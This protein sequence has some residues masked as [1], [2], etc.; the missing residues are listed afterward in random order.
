MPAPV[1]RNSAQPSAESREQFLQVDRC[2]DCVVRAHRQRLERSLRVD[3]GEG[4]HQGNRSPD[5]AGEGRER[6]L[7][8][9]IGQAGG[10]QNEIGRRSGWVFGVGPFRLQQLIAAARQGP[11]EPV[12]AR[13]GIA[14]KQYAARRRRIGQDDRN[15]NGGRERIRRLCPVKETK[16]CPRLSDPPAKCSAHTSRRRA[17][18]TLRQAGLRP[19]A[20]PPCSSSPRLRINGG[21][22]RST[23]KPAR[24][25][26][27]RCSARR[28][29]Q[30]C[31]TIRT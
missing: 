17:A 27:T 16:R 15:S 19:S 30:Q 8:A 28:C 24:D 3:I 14:Q 22:R 29:G 23:P 18:W 25:M 20:R 6:L 10:E 12:G 26:L 7:Q 5:L 13:S 11:L 2:G 31:R 1:R 21:N 4:D 9:L